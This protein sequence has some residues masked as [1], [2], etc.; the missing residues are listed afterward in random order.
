MCGITGLIAREKMDIGVT[1]VDMLY[2]LKHRG[3]DATGLAFYEDRKNIEI[4]VA[5]DGKEF[6]PHLES[7][8]SDYGKISNVRT[9]PSIGGY[10]F[11][12]AAVAMDYQKIPE[13]HKKIDAEPQLCVHH[14]GQKIKVYKDVGD[15]G[16]LRGHYDMHGISGTHG[17]GHVRLAT[18]SI[19]NINFAHPLV[20]YIYPELAIVH[21]GQLTN[22]F[23]MRRKLENLGVQ[24]KTYNDSE[25]IAHYLAYQMKERGKDLEEALWMG[26]EAFDGVFTFLASTPDQIG[27]VRD[28][29]AIKPVLFYESEEKLF[30]FG[31]EQT[32]M[33]PIMPDIFATEMDPGGAKVWS[34]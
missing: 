11:F 16:D 18:E 23:N 29:L 33:T 17:I 10:T 24:F 28:K 9:S 22:Y 12:E 26:L 34:V 4:K 15:A 14:L 7:M 20:S 27:A 6:Q 31:S 19:E 25:L 13:L 8:I 3:K 21:N 5:M 32:C 30:M 1:I 2:Q